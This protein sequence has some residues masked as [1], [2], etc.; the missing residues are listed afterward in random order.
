[1]GIKCKVLKQYISRLC[2]DNK[3]HYDNCKLL[4]VKKKLVRKGNK[5]SNKLSYHMQ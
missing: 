5:L 2:C 1:M 3:S 4:A